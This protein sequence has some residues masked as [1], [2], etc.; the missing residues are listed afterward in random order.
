MHTVGIHPV[1]E[2]N[3]VP[4]KN[5][6]AQER[7]KSRVLVVDDEEDLLELVRYNLSKEGYAVDCVGSG[8]E[9][10]AAARRQPPDL[11]VL[12]LMLPAVD[13]LEVCRRLK[14]DSKTRDIP[15]IMLTAKS[16]ESD[17]I[18]GLDRGADDYVAKPF[19]P[20]VL[21][22]RVKALL[23]REEARRRD[24]QETTIDVHELS[25]HPGR[26]EVTLAGQ[27]VDLTYTEFALLQ[28]LAK[29]PGWAYTRTQIVDAVK[30]E[31]YPVTERSVDV[32][33]A[34]LRRKLG[35]FGAYVE[36]V[37]GVGYRLRG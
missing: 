24:E 2:S 19:S 28:F 9:A 15:I 21:T 17:M 30:G 35:D 34:G 3:H 10:L 26:H 16:E 23:R 27:P 32:Q 20:R 6:A 31:D 5:R 29:R 22:A 1:A 33:V 8:E 13:G 12:D 4:V 11:L 25:I 37:R 7:T 14:S 36:T 18:A